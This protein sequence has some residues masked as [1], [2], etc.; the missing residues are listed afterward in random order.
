MT[1]SWGAGSAATGAA[2]ACDPRGVLVSG[3]RAVVEGARIDPP[4]FGGSTAC[5][6]HLDEPN[7]VLRVANL[8]DSG[9][10][11]VRSGK[12]TAVSGEQRHSPFTPWQ[13]TVAPAGQD[14]IEDQPEAAELVELMLEP[15][16]IVILATDG[17]FDNVYDDEI[18]SVIQVR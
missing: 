3:Y 9:F 11:L 15:G 18:E 5:L 2:A 14:M 8:G 4:V 12:V 1:N 16:D 6:G 13:L 10:R 7:G 17:L